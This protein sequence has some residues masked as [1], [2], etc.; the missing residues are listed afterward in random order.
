MTIEILKI[1][2]FMLIHGFYQN[3]KELKEEL[4]KTTILNEK[5]TEHS[6]GPDNFLH[7]MR[8]AKEKHKNDLLREKQ[9]ENGQ[10]VPTKEDDG[11]GVAETKLDD[12][13]GYKIVT[14]RASKRTLAGLT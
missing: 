9:Q 2:K 5:K 6:T 13:S 1:I 12:D 14:P 7:V 10:D 3:L 11:D 8:A 4:L